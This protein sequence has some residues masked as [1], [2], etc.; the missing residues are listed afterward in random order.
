MTKKIAII[1][2]DRELGDYIASLVDSYE[3]ELIVNLNEVIEDIALDFKDKLYWPTPV[4]KTDGGKHGHLRDNIAISGKVDDSGHISRTVHFGKKG[5]LATL[6]EYGWT[7]K[8]GKLVHQDKPF[9]RPTFEK[10][11]EEYFKWIK[12]TVEEQMGGG[13]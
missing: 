9:I 8:Y 2:L 5:W 7:S 6:L 11:K 4:S 12:K 3:K 10:H 13:K 1:D